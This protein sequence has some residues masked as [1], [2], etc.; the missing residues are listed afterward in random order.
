[1]AS[2]ILDKVKSLFGGENGKKMLDVI[3]GLANGVQYD[4]STGSTH[5]SA[6]GMVG[7]AMNSLATADEQKQ[8]KMLN[9]QILEQN[10]LALDEQKYKTEQARL[11]EDLAKKQQFEELNREGKAF[12][13]PDLAPRT[14]QFKK[15]TFGQAYDWSQKEENKGK[16]WGEEAKP[17]TLTEMK[18]GLQV[19]QG[20]KNVADVAWGD[21]STGNKVFDQALNANPLTQGLKQA[22]G[23]LGKQ[24]GFS[25]N[26]DENIKAA[27]GGVKG[28]FKVLY[29]DWNPVTKTAVKRDISLYKGLNGGYDFEGM[30]LVALNHISSASVLNPNML[31]DKDKEALL[32]A[33]ANATAR[34]SAVQKTIADTAAQMQSMG[35]PPAQINSM[36]QLSGQ[37]SAQKPEAGLLVAQSWQAI[38]KGDTAGAMQLAGQAVLRAMSTGSVGGF[39]DQADTLM[40]KANIAGTYNPPPVASAQLMSPGKPKVS[41]ENVKKFGKGK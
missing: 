15:S 37:V 22:A 27:G 38:M 33:Q 40:Q 5:L 34:K 2:D 32:V 16:R 23:A 17:Q 20:L 13:R 41:S 12:D 10:K 25:M 9:E 31:G 7:G 26:T 24:L 36:M 14:E 39:A 4:P 21:T 35:V 18:T 19:P 3:G 1:M 30:D 11:Q 28:A 6:T 8:K 29:D